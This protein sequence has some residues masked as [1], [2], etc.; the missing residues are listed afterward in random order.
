VERGNLLRVPHLDP[1]SSP[2]DWK[3]DFW[4]FRDYQD[5]FGWKAD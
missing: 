1:V 3:Q 4:D 5:F 2:T